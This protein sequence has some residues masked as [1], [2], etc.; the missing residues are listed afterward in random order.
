MP[1]ELVCITYQETYPLINTLISHLILNNPESQFRVSGPKPDKLY[2]YSGA[3][4]DGA[5]TQPQF[6]VQEAL[7]PQNARFAAAPPWSRKASPPPL[8]L[9][10]KPLR[11]VPVR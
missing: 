4:R 2:G 1:G 10:E 7:R 3:L 6:L 9:E 8:T 11:A 5:F